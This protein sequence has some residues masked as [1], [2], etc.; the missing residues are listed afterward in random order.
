[1]RTACRPI[2]LI[3]LLSAVLVIVFSSHAFP[4]AS[5]P[6]LAIE[7][8]LHSASLRIMAT[9]A[10]NRFLVTGSVDKTVRV[11]DLPTG[12]LLGILRPPIGKANEGIILAVDV[13]PDGD[14]IACGGRTRESEKSSQV[15]LFDRE[16]R[17]LLKRISGLPESITFLRFSRDGSMLAVGLAGSGGL[18][19][20]SISRKGDRIDTAPAGD[21]PSYG[22]SIRGMDFDSAGRL[23]VSSSDGA[24]R[25]YSREFRAD[26]E[27]DRVQGRGPL[28]CPVFTGRFPDC[29][30][31]F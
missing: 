29:P 28:G 22:D 11:W 7:A 25:L 21:D 4:Q 20:F 10:K 15:Y 5:E 1:M 12:K 19:I 31:V 6:I 9:D 18:R 26:R 27:A 30:G 13:S 2:A 16:S 24:L 14:T 23:A 17:R 8:G 3:L